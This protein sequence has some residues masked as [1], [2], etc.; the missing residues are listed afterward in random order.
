MTLTDLGNNFFLKKYEQLGMSYELY[1]FKDGEKM[2]LHRENGPAFTAK[3][4][5]RLVSESY[6][7]LGE[8]Q[9]S[10]DYDSE[11]NEF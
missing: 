6:Y 1:Y 8:L 2:L 7:Y 9:S 10:K 3:Y 11:G 4:Q 5:D